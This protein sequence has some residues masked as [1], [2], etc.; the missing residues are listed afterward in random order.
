MVCNARTTSPNRSSGIKSFKENICKHSAQ[1]GIRAYALQQIKKATYACNH[2]TDPSKP[3]ALHDFRVAV[4][5]LR[6]WLRVFKRYH[7]VNK[8]S[9]KHL[10]EIT[11][12]TNKSRD[13]EVCRDWLKEYISETDSMPADCMKELT[14]LLDRMTKDYE[15]EF[16][17]IKNDV[18]KDWKILDVYLKKQLDTETEAQKI[19]GTLPHVAGKN[20]LN[21]CESI[22][23]QIAL[24]H[25]IDDRTA[26]HKLRIYFKRLRYLLEPFRYRLSAL[27]EAINFLK[28]IQD[29]L[30]DF[31][32]AHIT[33]DLLKTYNKSHDDAFGDESGNAEN[34]Q[35]TFDNL[36]EQAKHLELDRFG[37]FRK[38]YINGEL[39]R[40]ISTIRLTADKMINLKI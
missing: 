24:I 23:E 36:R 33:I 29:I 35:I 11:D 28:T 1:E 15:L 9:I 30:G 14:M 18:P 39:Q 17:K 25:S 5:R 13:L 26:I 20:I 40:I 4:R 37:H 10:G 32:D 12:S 38:L 7:N 22:D 27:N 16:T 3:D 34:Q 21:I 6:T 31:R 2:L 8:R 19:K